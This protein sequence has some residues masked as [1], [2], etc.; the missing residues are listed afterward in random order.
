MIKNFLAC[1]EHRNLHGKDKALDE[2]E[3][4]LEQAKAVC[5]EVANAARFH[6]TNIRCCALDWNRC[7]CPGNR[8]QESYDIAD[9]SLL[10]A[11][12]SVNRAKALLWEKG[13][14]FEQHD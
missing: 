7:N 5:D 2:A 10:A 4:R 3:E 13:V 12:G 11:L 1:S 8:R 6:L 9:Q 14:E